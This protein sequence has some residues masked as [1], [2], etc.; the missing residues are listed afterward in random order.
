MANNNWKERKVGS[1]WKKEGKDL[2]TGT[3]SINGKDVKVIA[4]VNNDK[5]TSNSP[6]INIYLS[7]ETAAPASPAKTSPKPAATKKPSVKPD[8]N[9][10]IPF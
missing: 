2:Y 7:E 9:D 1:L 5:Q 8:T 6:D 4:F 10:N 3:I